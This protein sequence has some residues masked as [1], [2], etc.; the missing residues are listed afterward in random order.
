MQLRDFARLVEPVERFAAGSIGRV[1]GRRIDQS[2]YILEFSSHDRVEVPAR[3]VEAAGQE[4][5]SPVL[6]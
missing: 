4:D 5:R 6:N 1:V 3:M 2:S